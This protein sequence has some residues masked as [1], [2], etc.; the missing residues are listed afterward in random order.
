M[1]T[2]DAVL[3]AKVLEGCPTAHFLLAKVIDLEYYQ[4]ELAKKYRIWSP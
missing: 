4:P 1:W 2:D 3:D